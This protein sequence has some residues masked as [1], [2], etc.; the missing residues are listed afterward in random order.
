M[1]SDARPTDKKAADRAHW[2]IAQFPLGEE[3]DDDVSA[4]TTP[5]ERIAMMWPLAESA[6]KVARR[7]LPTYDRRVIPARL[8]RAGNP[9]PDDE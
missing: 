9:P 7:P 1:G 4:H 8:F 3:P 5:A 6:W 2:P